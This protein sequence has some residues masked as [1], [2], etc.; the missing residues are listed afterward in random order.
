MTE[1]VCTYS[2]IKGITEVNKEK[3]L[4]AKTLWQ[5]QNET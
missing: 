5:E 1:K 4:Q 3:I 2:K